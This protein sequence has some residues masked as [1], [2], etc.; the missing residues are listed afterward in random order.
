M[1]LQPVRDKICER[2][3]APLG[4]SSQ[5]DF[6]SA[7]TT[8]GSQRRQLIQE[9]HKAANPSGEDHDRIVAPAG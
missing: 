3:R 2:V 1:V 6:R 4:L 5:I 8:Y 9:S 7:F